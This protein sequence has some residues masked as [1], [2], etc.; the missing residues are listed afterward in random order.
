MPL[1]HR[2][3]GHRYRCRRHDIG[4]RDADG[5]GGGIPRAVAGHDLELVDIVAIGIGRRLVIRCADEAHLPGGAVD[6]E[7]RDV[8]PPAQAIRDGLAVGVDRVEIVD[9]RLVLRHL[10]REDGREIQRRCEQIGGRGATG[11]IDVGHQQRTRLRSVGDPELAVAARIGRLEQDLAVEQREV[12]GIEQALPGGAEQPVGAELG[13]IRNPQLPPVHPV[14]RREQDDVSKHREVRGIRAAGGVDV[15]HQHRVRLGPVGDPQL[16]PVGAVVGGKDHTV[17]EYSQAGR[18]RAILPRPY[19]LQQIRPCVRTVGGVKLIVGTATARREQNLVAENGEVR[20]KRPVGST[21]EVVQHH[22][23]RVG[24][25]GDPRLVPAVPVGGREY[26][27]IAEQGQ[28]ARGAP[29]RG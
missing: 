2:D 16:R 23:T 17:P 9:R 1:G 29:A 11:R 13:S 18:I 26:D 3:V 14:F 28:L 7:E 10:D 5:L 22:R 25:V 20:R 21:A 12:G 24:P 27:L 8:C 4:D 15:G 6:G 19:L